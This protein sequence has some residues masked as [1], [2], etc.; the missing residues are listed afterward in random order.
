MKRKKIYLSGPMTGYPNSNYPAFER[1]ASALRDNGHEVFSPHE[2]LPEGKPSNADLRRAF[3]AYSKYICEEADTIVLLPGW[4][5]S[6]GV[7]AELAL[8]KNCG[9]NIEELT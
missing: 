3:S 9:L 7:S 2:F 4:E 6:I 1:A 5:K 8:A